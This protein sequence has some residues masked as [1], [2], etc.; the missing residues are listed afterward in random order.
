MARRA[1]LLRVDRNGATDSEL[2]VHVTAA[3]ET[4]VKLALATPGAVAVALVGSWARGNARPDSDVDLV[5]LTQR[6]Q[7]LLL[8]D[9]WHGQFGADAILV[10]TADFGA[11]QERRLRLASGLEVEVCI[12]HPSWADTDPVD[13]GTRRVVSDGIRVLWD[14]Y[15]RLSALIEA[16]H[17]PA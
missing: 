5:F 12:G 2:P 15:L 3:S 14:P 9:R 17:A 7:V 11:V 1:A 4:A 16:V 8:D 10:R 13:A 6:P